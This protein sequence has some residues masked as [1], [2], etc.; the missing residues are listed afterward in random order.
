[1]REELISSTLIKMVRRKHLRNMLAKRIDDYIYKSIAANADEDLEK[2]RL[3]R[4][5]FMSAMLS[6]VVR[7]I[8][9]GY[10]NGEITKRIIKVLIQKNFIRRDSDSDLAA[11]RFKEKYGQF[12][13]TFIVFSPTQKCN[14]KCIGCYAASASD[15]AA[16]IP[17]TIVDRVVR[18]VHDYFGARFITISGGEPFV[19]KSEGKTLLDIFEKYNDIYF[20][21]YINGLVIN[22]KTAQRLAKARNVTPAIS[23]EGFEAETDGRRGPG[24]YKRILATFELLRQAGVPF[25]ISVTATSKNV[26][27]LL[28]DEFYDFYFQ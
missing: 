16:T 19:Y 11:N 1:M 10:V 21:V 20:L 24:V 9:K 4:Y 14:L 15:T 13:P 2:V 27:T 26:E 23:V 22:D 5:Q 8:D 17:F 12:P 6:C 7:N 18:E 28:R 25:G 3:R